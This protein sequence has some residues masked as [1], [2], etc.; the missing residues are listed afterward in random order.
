MENIKIQNLTTFIDEIKTYVTESKNYERACKLIFQFNDL[1]QKKLEIWMFIEI[2]DKP[3]PIFKNVSFVEV[4]ECPNSLFYK[5][6]N[7]Q[8]FNI[9]K[10]LTREYWH[11]NTFQELMNNL[12]EIEMTEDFVGFLE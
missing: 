6:E 1:M 9:D 2:K 4:K 12:E 10:D 3:K 5:V 11:Y 7:E 8:V